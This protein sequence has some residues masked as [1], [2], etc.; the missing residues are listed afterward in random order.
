MTKNIHNLETYFKD[1][2]ETTETD[3][4]V[5]NLVK[6]S[7]AILD[8]GCGFNQYKKYNENLVGIDIVNKNADHICDIID[9]ENKNQFDLIICFGSLHFYN[10]DWINLRLKKVINMLTSNATICMKVNPA[11]PNTDGSYLPWFEKWTPP[12]VEHFAEL[13]NLEIKNIREGSRNRLKW[14]YIKK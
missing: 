12:L 7:N 9:Y 4:H 14:D 8:V 1:Q 13:Y 11:I 5:V 3:S 6:K 10:Y 2:W